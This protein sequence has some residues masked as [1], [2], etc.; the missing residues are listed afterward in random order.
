MPEFYKG[1]IPIIRNGASLN[2]GFL[3]GFDPD[4]LSTEALHGIPITL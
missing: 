3:R 4:H 1:R 2:A